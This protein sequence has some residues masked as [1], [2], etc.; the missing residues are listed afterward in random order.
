MVTGQPVQAIAPEYPNQT[1]EFTVG[2]IMCLVA[3][4]AILAKKNKKRQK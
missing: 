3:V 2:F 1:L 4:T